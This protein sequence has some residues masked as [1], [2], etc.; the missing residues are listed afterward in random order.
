M[1]AHVSSAWCDD[2]QLHL[3][4]L[5]AGKTLLLETGKVESLFVTQCFCLASATSIA[6][7]HQCEMKITQQIVPWDRSGTVTL[8]LTCGAAV[9]CMWMVLGMAAPVLS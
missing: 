2:V 7:Q 4:D 3:I 5:Q 8:Q 9:V 1:I 6:A